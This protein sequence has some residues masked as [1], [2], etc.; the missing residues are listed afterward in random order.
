MNGKPRH[1]TAPPSTFDLKVEGKQAYVTFNG[2]IDSTVVGAFREV[3]ISLPPD[4]ELVVLDAKAVSF[5][6][7][8]AVRV[9]T[10]L[11]NKFSG[12]VVVL[13]PPPTLKFLLEIT[14]LADLVTIQD[15]GSN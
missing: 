4:L 12:R 5:I 11:A 8:Y 1:T 7:S 2:D 9:L 3:A 14:T 10:D 15:A 13:N 6:D